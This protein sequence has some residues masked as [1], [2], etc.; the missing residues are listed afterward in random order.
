MHK[1]LRRARD[2]SEEGTGNKRQKTSGSAALVSP[3]ELGSG[4]PRDPFH[5]PLSEKPNASGCYHCPVGSCECAY[6]EGALEGCYDTLSCKREIVRAN[7]SDLC[8]KSILPP[9]VARLVRVSKLTPDEIF[10]DF[11]CGNGS[12]LFQVAYLTGCRC[13][14]IEINPTNAQVAREAWELLRPTLERRCGRTLHV[15]IICADFCQLLKD[16]GF[17]RAKGIIWAANLLLPRPVNHYLSER[18]RAVPLGTRIF[19]FEDLYP[20]GRAVAR[21]RDPDAFERFEMT[22]YRW[23]PSTVEWCDLEGP[24]YQYTRI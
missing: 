7:R 8:A 9:F 24:F 5:L 13:V 11:G 3:V 20:H 19:C 12:V 2:S 16:D 4:A 6:L 21:T 1:Y 18:F 15:E 14:G 22:D 10:Y 23:Q 17:F